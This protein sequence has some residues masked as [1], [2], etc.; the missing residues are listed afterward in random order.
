MRDDVVSVYVGKRCLLYIWKVLS[1]SEECVTAKTIN[2][3][4]SGLTPPTQSTEP[5][6]N[7]KTLTISLQTP[8]PQR[9][10]LLSVPRS[11][12]VATFY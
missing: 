1:G 12:R 10:T 2:L 4:P 5:W 11:V 8:V 6:L 7:M 9:L 3:P